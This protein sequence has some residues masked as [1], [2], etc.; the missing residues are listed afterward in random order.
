MPHTKSQRPLADDYKPVDWNSLQPPKEFR[1]IELAP[2]S[3]TSPLSCR[4]TENTFQASDG[5]YLALSYA[6]GSTELCKTIV[7]NG[8]LVRI[9]KNLHSALRRFR[10][11]TAALNVWCDALCIK[12]GDDP[13]SLQER[14]EQIPLMS[15]I[16][17]SASRVLVDLG[18]DDGTV[19]IALG[20]I[21]AILKLPKELLKRTYSEANPADF[22][23]LPPYTDPSWSALGRLLSRS[24]FQRIWCVQEAVLARDIKVVFGDSSVSFQGLVSIAMVFMA[25]LRA[26]A[27]YRTR[28]G[29][30][31][32]DSS[33]VTNAISSLSAIH[34]K[35]QERLDAVDVMPVD[36]CELIRSTLNEQSTDRR[37]RV[38]ALYGLVGAHV[39]EDLPVDY[40]EPVHQLSH[41]LSLYLIAHGNGAWALTHS[42]GVTGNCPSW[43]LDLSTLGGKE[44]MDYLSWTTDARGHSFVYAAGGP[45]SPVIRPDDGGRRVKVHGTVVEGLFSMAEAFHFPIDT[46]V[47]LEDGAKLTPKLTMSYVLWLDYVVDWAAGFVGLNPEALWRTLIADFDV[48]GYTQGD[49]RTCHPVS[50]FGSCFDDLIVWVRSIAKARPPIDVE[51]LTP[52]ELDG[53]RLPPQGNR[54]WQAMV[55]PLLGRRLACVASGA[56]ALIPVAA[57]VTDVIAVLQGVP[58]PFLLRPADDGYCVLGTCY[59][60]GMMNGEALDRGLQVTEF[61]LR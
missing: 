26:A 8:H 4:V 54:F 5:R 51:S 20:L 46:M 50:E 57:E 9:T 35:R 43:S 11:Q 24:W 7:C 3:G 16:F 60:H 19:S 29:W 37:D 30:E 1:L 48:F 61:L 12:Q 34:Q 55:A 49:P 44:R 39:T 40:S 18:P 15:R 33:R 32:L 53:Y 47:G 58:L 42:G 36:L 6:W 23:N 59:V 45:N 22:F 27:R 38:Y 25:V 52:E 28:F 56:L 13:A 10:S 31:L 2:G 41:R 21:N 14:A 17:G